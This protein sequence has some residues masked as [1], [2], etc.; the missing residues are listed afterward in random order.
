MFRENQIPIPQNLAGLLL[1]AVISDTLLFQSPTTTPKDRDV[2]NILGALAD[3]DVETFGKEMFTATASAPGQSIREMIVQDIKYYNINGARAMIA[4]VMVGSA[5]EMKNRSSEIMEDC[6][7]L[8][9][10]KE[11]DLLVVAFTSIAEHG[12]IFYMTGEKASRALNAFP[13]KDGEENSFQEGIF[14]RKSQIL[15]RITDALIK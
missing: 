3:L 5:M 15:P 4:Q 6:S 11:L 1:G 14:S 10:K 9:R 13:N 2:A 7:E 12:S 8:T